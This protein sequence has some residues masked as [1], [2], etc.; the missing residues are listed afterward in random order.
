MSGSAS[1]AATR[2]RRSLR[3]LRAWAARRRLQRRLA[4]PQLLRAFAAST[5][6]AFFV[7]IGANDGKQHDH[8][9][10]LILAGRWRGVMVEPVPYIY[11]RLRANYEGLDR[12]ALENVAIADREG[13]LPFFHVREAAG[14]ERADLPDWYDGIGSFSRDAVLAHAD[15]VP[16]L[17]DL[18]VETEVPCTTYAALRTRHGDP[19]VDLLLIDTEGHDWEI[20]KSIDLSSAPPQLIVYEHFHLDPRDRAACRAH[21]HA[22]GYETMEEGFDTFCLA[23]GSDPELDR[24]WRELR[25]GV[26]GVFADRSGGDAPEDLPLHDVRSPLPPGAERELHAE[27]PRLREL[28]DAY[29]R[30]DLPA[31]AESRWTRDAVEGFLDLRFFRGETLITWHYREL[32]RV[33]ELKYFVLLRYVAERDDQRLLGRLEEDGGFGCWTFSYPGHAPVSRDL[34][35]SVNELGFLERTLALSRRERFS[36]LDVGA[37]YGRLA[38]RTAAAY[39]N[40]ADYCCVDAV[41][42]ATFLSEYY[43]RHRGVAPPARVVELGAVETE[44]E[45]GAFDLAVN[46]H[47]FS[48]CPLAAIEWWI[49][50]LAR[51]AVPRLLIVPNEPEALLSLES[52]GSRHDFAPLLERAGYRLTIREPAIDD[53]AMRE[54]VGIE[55]RFHLY[56]LRE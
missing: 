47:S 34:L 8:L 10:P 31:L 46:V 37:G 17:G 38:H 11:D 42:E 54:L 36:V 14:P 2:A 24:I 27:N 5:P 16:G 28:R 25:P 20:L 26:A 40:L 4:G 13:T 21:L 51:L 15:H 30:L 52:D 45:T 43:L 23:T 32:P 6:D 7:E 22:A 35:E 49:G 29:A 44:L 53:P 19:H 3:G 18:I 1:G 50:L 48:E 41:P 39:P 33:T 12:V 9:R 55:D 56:A